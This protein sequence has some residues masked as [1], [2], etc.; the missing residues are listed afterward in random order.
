MFVVTSS[1]SD[2]EPRR[3]GIAIG[4]MPPLRGPEYFGRLLLQTRRPSG[5]FV[6][7]SNYYKSLALLF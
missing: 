5:P 4:S 2:I 7:G 3:G 6:K 1:P